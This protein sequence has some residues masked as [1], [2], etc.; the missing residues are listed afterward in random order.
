MSD[1]RRPA[2]S[3][4]QGAA[5][6]DGHRAASGA[7]LV[8]AL[9]GFAGFV[10]LT[11]LVATQTAISF[12]QPL[13]DLARGWDRYFDLWNLLSNAANFP[14]IGLGVAIVDRKSVV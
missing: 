12:D 7:W 6:P 13:L 3:S 1:P 2:T 11:W 8:V 10:L 5:A 14:L 9:L 4:D